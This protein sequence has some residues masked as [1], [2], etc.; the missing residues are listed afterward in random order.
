MQT[1]INKEDEAEYIVRVKSR[2][3]WWL[4]LFLLLLLPA[5][6]LLRFDKDVQFTTIEQVSKEKIKDV[7]V[8]FQYVDFSFIKTKPFRF[9]AADTIKLIGV[10]NENGEVVFTNVNYSLFSVIF[11]SSEPAI[12]TASGGC[13][14][15]DTLSTPFQKLSKIFPTEIDLLKD[16]VNVTVKVVDKEDGEPLPN[17]DVK[18][19]IS[20]QIVDLHTDATGYAEIPG[21]ERCGNLNVIASMEGYSSDTI[22]ADVAT[23]LQGEYNSTLALKPGKGV[24]SFTIKDLETKLNI[25][26][27]TAKLVLEGKTEDITTNTNGVGKGYFEDIKA[28]LN[29]HIDASKIC[30]HDTSTKTY[31]VAGYEKLKEED[32]IIYLRP[33]KGSVIFRNIDSL[34]NNPIE[35]VT[36]K[37]FINGEDKGIA[38]SN[39]QGCFTIGNIGKNDVVKIISTKGGYREKKWN[40][41]GSDITNNQHTRDIPMLYMMNPAGKP[42]PTRN[43]GVH[44]SGTLLADKEVK[45]HISKIYVPDMYGE[46]VGDGKYISNQLAFPKAVQYTFDAIAV[47]KG[48]HIKLYSKPNFQGEVLLDVHGP[49]LINNCKWQ[50]E[51][52]IKDFI[53][54]D[55][56]PVLEANYPKS[57]RH[58]SKTNMNSWDF[59]SVI[60]TCDK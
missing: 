13:L 53:T 4:L 41:K 60:I 50:N 20:G 8:D 6:L 45:G 2:N 43:C 14:S 3:Y 7:N 22:N 49:Y 21:V 11:H 18:A 9:F 59:G 57:C 33:E 15:A 37:I 55:F 39:R 58:W 47:D 10:S 27:A 24:I 54:R 31:K 26:G 40:R 23:I 42:N 29:F 44:F 12:I 5:L 36:N 46:Y 32:K 28:S 51:A 35:G 38:Y 34:T 16:R 25:A 56:E 52:R 48:T 17:A 19:D 30:Y 1:Y